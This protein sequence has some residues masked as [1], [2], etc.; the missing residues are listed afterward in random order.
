MKPTTQA[1]SDLIN[2]LV[3]SFVEHPEAIKIA[4]QESDDGLACYWMMKGHP[5]DESILVG[6]SG[7][8]VDALTFLISE[9]GAANRESYTFRL[10]T[11]KS[12]EPHA[13]LAPR[14]VMDYNPARVVGLLSKILKALDIGTFTVRTSAGTGQRRSL[15]FAFTIEV[16]DI[17]AYGVLTD[18]K[19][20]YPNGPEDYTVE[21]SLG[22]LLRAIGKHDGVRFNVSVLQPA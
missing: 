7:S 12:G 6:F 10:L 16:Q 4:A 20:L 19:P 15:T 1:T 8:H 11:E 14:D 21:G 17:A 22:T 13:S 3:K 2:E 5:A 9:V 18:G